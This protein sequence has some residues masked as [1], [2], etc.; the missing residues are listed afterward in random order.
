MRQ[1]FYLLVLIFF[2]SCA[3]E[4]VQPYQVIIS[5]KI[6]NASG[7]KSIRLLE[8]LTNEPVKDIHFQKDGT[9][10]DTLSLNKGHYLFVLSDDIMN[11]VP[12]YINKSDDV[13]LTFDYKNIE[14]TI[15][16]NSNNKEV[17]DYLYFKR[18]YNWPKDEKVAKKRREYF[19]GSEENFKVYV[20]KQKAFLDSILS[21]KKL[22]K[23]FV[24]LE[25][26][27]LHYNYLYMLSNFEFLHSLYIKDKNFKVSK[28]FLDELKTIE[29]NNVNDFNYSYSYRNIYYQKF[30][31]EADFLSKKLEQDKNLIMITQL[32]KIENEFIRNQLLFKLAKTGITRTK[33]TQSLF[34]EFVK[35][36]TNESHKTILR[37]MYL[38]KTRLNKGRISPKFTNYRNI[39][40]TTTS[41]DDLKGK[42]VY[43]DFWAT[44][45]APCKK[46]FPY[47]KKLEKKYKHDNIHFVSISLDKENK[48]ELWKKMIKENNLGGIQLFADKDFDSEFAKEYLITSI[49]KFVLLDP[50]GRIISTDA[51]RPSDKKLEVLFRSLRIKS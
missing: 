28:H 43:I 44:W 48:F 17:N 12:V 33:N 19:K 34:N 11:A 42:Y 24:L 46:E 16:L 38:S 4:E 36:S 40:K 26:K 9:F 5:G 27:H 10:L 15:S 45:C 7:I 8:L 20:S 3:K 32:M 21:S 37:R 39:D 47:L 41:L 49:P 2:L 13:S 14:E 35:S 29:F 22:D 25:K 30:Q 1:S 31:K 23:K 51:P 18:R 6:T 50:Q